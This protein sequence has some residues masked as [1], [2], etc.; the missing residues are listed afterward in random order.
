M[1]KIRKKNIDVFEMLY[2]LIGIPWLFLVIVTSQ[3]LTLIKTILLAILVIVSC[4]EILTYKKK[5]SLK[6]IIFLLIFVLYFL[7]NLLLG[8][9][10]GYKFNFLHDFSLIQNY[11]LTPIFI[12]ILAM[13]FKDNKNRQECLLKV[14]IIIVFVLLSMN[15][16]KICAVKGIFPSFAVLDLITQTSDISSFGLTIRMSNETSLF[17]LLPFII[18]LSLKQKKNKYSILIYLSIIMGIIYGLLSGRKILEIVIVVSLVYTYI[19]KMSRNKKVSINKIVKSII[20]IVLILILLICL[21]NYFSSVLDLG[22]IFQEALK[23]ITNG[24]DNNAIGLIKRKNDINNLFEMWINSPLIGLGLNSYTRDAILYK[25]CLWSYEV[26]YNALLAQSG[27]IGLL[28]VIIPIVYIVKR[29]YIQL[30]SNGSIVSL[31]I[32][33]GFIMFV[34]SAAT[35]PMLYLIWPWTISLIKYEI[36][37]L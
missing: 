4:I 14:L 9:A 22:N 19:H 1:I 2:L 3:Q 30:K 18:I 24:L 12:I 13:I 17:F 15:L 32:A 7:L 6:E 27:I 11:L 20:I 5:I 37:E 33:F 8:I 10:N 21:S 36:K 28:L 34:I 16:I 26:Y 29:H 35:N 31:A 23:T 25:E